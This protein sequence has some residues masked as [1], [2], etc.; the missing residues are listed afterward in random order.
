MEGDMARSRVSWSHSGVLPFTC[1]TVAVKDLGG[2]PLIVLPIVREGAPGF[3][4]YQCRLQ[5]VDGVKISHFGALAWCRT[6]PLA[7]ADSTESHCAPH[8]GR[9][10]IRFLG[11]FLLLRNFPIFVFVGLYSFPLFRTSY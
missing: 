8:P 9:Y 7:A 1:L 11:R 4:A 3:R 10:I 2:L 6:F 5:G